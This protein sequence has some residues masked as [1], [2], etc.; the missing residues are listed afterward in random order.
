MVLFKINVGLN[1]Y[2]PTTQ[3]SVSGL[4]NGN[5]VDASAYQINIGGPASLSLSQVTWRVWYMY[6]DGTA[7]RHRVSSN[8][9][10]NSDMWPIASPYILSPDM[11]IRA[12]FDPYNYRHSSE[13][14]YGIELDFSDYSA[15][16]LQYDSGVYGACIEA[17]QRMGES[18][19]KVFKEGTVI[20]VPSNCRWNS[21]VDH[22]V[23]LDPAQKQY[24]FYSSQIPG[25]AL[26]ARTAFLESFI[27]D[28]TPFVGSYHSVP[29]NFRGSNYNKLTQLLNSQVQK[30]S[31]G[32]FSTVQCMDEDVTGSAIN[33]IKGHGYHIMNIKPSNGFN[34]ELW[35]RNF[36][37]PFKP[38]GTT[39]G[40]H[41]PWCNNSYGTYPSLENCF[42]WNVITFVCVDGTLKNAG[43]ISN[44]PN[45]GA[46]ANSNLLP[47]KNFTYSGLLVK[48]ATTNDGPSGYAM[49]DGEWFD[50]K[51]CPSSW[52]MSPS[53]DIICHS[54]QMKWCNMDP[55][56]ANGA[57]GFR[58]FEL[59]RAGWHDMTNAKL[60]A[61]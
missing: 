9:T 26:P 39:Y 42:C 31:I 28:T 58:R 5:L 32:T 54:S 20:N 19:G 29:R 3:D 33:K 48:S 17:I 60:N 61:C 34:P 11:Y 14:K 47:K 35:N 57:G 41:I 13:N 16:V 36:N 50:F 40:G 22:P 6:F 37:F 51:I 45:V 46:V 55:I 27:D 24:M 53:W 44:C 38:D 15:E 25:Y 43:F 10:F 23:P 18:S 56:T 12:D 4:W 7:I 49:A 1:L 2:G 21:F 8:I 59:L 52:H 30:E